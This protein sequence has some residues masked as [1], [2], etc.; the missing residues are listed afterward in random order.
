M[1]GRAIHFGYDPEFFIRDG[2]NP[3]PV[4]AHRAFDPGK[5]ENRTFFRDGA[6]VEV[7][8]PPA[9]CIALSINYINEVIK[10]ARE[11]LVRNFPKARFF[12][13]SAEAFDPDAWSDAPPDV[14]EVGCHPSW[15][16]YTMKE[17]GAQMDLWSHPYRYGGGHM[18]FSNFESVTDFASAVKFI[19]LLDWKVGLLDAYFFGGEKAAL[20][21]RFYGLAGDFRFH[22]AEPGTSGYRLINGR[23]HFDGS[24]YKPY[25]PMR[26][27]YRTPGPEMWRM[28][29]IFV[30]LYANIAR[31]CDYQLE[32][33]SE[34]LTPDLQR[35]VRNAINSGGDGAEELLSGMSFSVGFTRKEVDLTKSP[36]YSVEVLK[37]IKKRL[38]SKERI[39]LKV[40]TVN[41]H[42]GFA[43]YMEMLDL[44]KYIPG[45]VGSR[46]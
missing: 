17:Q 7:N 26:V 8:A 16:A 45:F 2:K 10:L 18:H 39:L 21:R 23:N 35:A 3:A 38:L 46:I 12:A 27:E 6:A 34:Q 4:P 14:M 9:T 19:R 44:T 43:D 41:A 1:E 15:N 11:R 28:P 33:L 5:G 42:K 30:S 29:N 32:R 36:I 22:A 40:R 25:K 37:Q 31:E 24:I 20:R 13:S